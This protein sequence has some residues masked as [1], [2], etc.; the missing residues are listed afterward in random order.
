MDEDVEL[1][2]T[3]I[4]LELLELELE[5]LEL[6]LEL[7]ELELLSSADATIVMENIKVPA[8]NNARDFFK[9]IWIFLLLSS[10]YFKDSIFT[11]GG[12][13]IY[14]ILEKMLL[15]LAKGGIRAIYVFSFLL[16]V[17]RYSLADIP[18]SFLNTL[19]K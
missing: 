9:F 14:S 16:M 1:L 13:L 8:N 3:L 15:F 19:E 6:E 11:G 10:V 2:L 4:E 5:L 17:F 12:Y 7:M 18:S